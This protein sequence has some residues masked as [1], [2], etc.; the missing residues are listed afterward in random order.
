MHA[1]NIFDATT[2]SRFKS[3]IFILL[4]TS[5]KFSLNVEMKHYFLLS[6]FSVFAMALT[7]E[8]KLNQI[9]PAEKK[10]PIIFRDYQSNIKEKFNKPENANLLFS[11][12]MGTQ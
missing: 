9:R 1:I 6:I 3:R 8:L 12:L 10:V 4:V 2:L 7:V 5:S 11:F